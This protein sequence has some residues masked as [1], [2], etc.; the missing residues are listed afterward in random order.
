MSNGFS[1]PMWLFFKI[2]HPLL[3]KTCS[4]HFKKQGPFTL[5]DLLKDKKI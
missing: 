5:N 4:K 1:K 2:L 3:L